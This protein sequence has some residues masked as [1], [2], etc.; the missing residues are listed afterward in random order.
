MSNI[1]IKKNGGEGGDAVRISS[2]STTAV[3]SAATATSATITITA[4]SPSD[5]DV[6]CGRGAGVNNHPGNKTYRKLI[7][8]NKELY[9]ATSF[10]KKTKLQISL[11]IVATIRHLGGRFLQRDTK[12]NKNGVV[13]WVDIG[14]KKAVSK[15][16]QGLRDAKLN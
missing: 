7:N 5:I 2:F 4:T 16:S 3:I 15:T 11:S 14:D 1:N 12:N 8:A 10:S 13:W 6:L 9:A